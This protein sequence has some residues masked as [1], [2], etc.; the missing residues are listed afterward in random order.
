MQL[1]AKKKIKFFIL[2]K[3]KKGAHCLE[4]DHEKIISILIEFF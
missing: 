2:F 1:V 4:L 3:F